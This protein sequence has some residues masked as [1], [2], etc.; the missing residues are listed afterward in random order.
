MACIIKEL[1]L[2]NPSI[3]FWYE[4][5]IS[6]KGEQVIS[7]ISSD[8]I[9]KEYANI[10][11]SF[12]E[13]VLCFWK[14]VRGA[15]PEWLVQVTTD[16]VGVERVKQL[17]DE[18]DKLELQITKENEIRLKQEKERRELESAKLEALRRERLAQQEL[19]R[20]A[21]PPLLHFC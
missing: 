8:K 3:Y 9:T 6:K 15:L 21:P 10:L 1:F 5:E 20:L 7:V 11:P 14:D 19:Q 2:S 17:K 12:T 13:K 4:T 18:R 16:L